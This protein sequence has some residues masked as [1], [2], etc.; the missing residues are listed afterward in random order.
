MNDSN[1]KNA[2]KVVLEFEGGFVDNPIDP[3]G[4]TNYGITQEV[5]NNENTE[6]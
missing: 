3:G 1:F 4:R 2:L 6:V 5:Y